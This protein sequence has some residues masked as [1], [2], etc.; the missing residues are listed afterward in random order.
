MGRLGTVRRRAT[1]ITSEAHRRY[2]A[3]DEPSRVAVARGWSDVA[4][5]HLHIAD[6]FTLLALEQDYP[7][8]LIAVQWRPLPPPFLPGACEAFIDILEVR[9]EVRR[10]GIATTLVERSAARA[11]ARGAYQLRAWSSQDKTEALCLW[12]TLGFGLCPAVTSAQGQ[13]VSGYFV[14]KVLLPAEVLK[15][16]KYA[17]EKGAA[18]QPRSADDP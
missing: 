10:Q 15:L 2:I 11:Q 5:R 1:P 9:P 3:A 7:V 4:A 13:A 14:A 16:G 12:Q 17:E 6:G 8:G 18:V